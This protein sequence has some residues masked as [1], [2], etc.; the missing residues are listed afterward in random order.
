MITMNS[1]APPL[2][3]KAELESLRHLLAILADPDKTKRRLEEL[4][5]AAENLKR[6]QDEHADK[7][8]QLAAVR[9]EHERKLQEAK[10]VHDKVLAEDR[11]AFANECHARL[12]AIKREEA[13][14][15]HLKGLLDNHLQEMAQMNRG[16]AAVA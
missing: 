6:R 16:R 14:V 2:V 7:A 8:S 15:E 5:A 4:T 3:V 12:E 11:V 10:A 9:I 13:R 1:P